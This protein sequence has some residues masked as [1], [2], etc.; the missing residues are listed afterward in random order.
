MTGTGTTTRDLVLTNDGTANFTM[1][2]VGLSAG[3]TRVTNNVTGNCGTTLLSGASCSIRVQWAVPTAVGSATGTVTITGVQGSPIAIIANAV[4]PTYTAS[5]SPSAI[6][7]GNWKTGTTGKET[8]T[9]TNTGNS[10]LTNLALNV[11]GP[12]ALGTS[13][14]ATAVMQVGSV[15][16]VNRGSYAAVPT[17][18]L[19]G[20]GSVTSGTATALM[21]VINPTVVS[22]NG[23]YTNVATP[24]VTFSAPAC[25]NNV[26]GVCQRATGTVTMSSNNQTNATRRVASINLNNNGLGY[27]S[28]PTIAFS[29][30]PAT[31]TA[32]LGV[33]RVTVTDGGTDY[34]T[35]PTVTF[36]AGTTLATGTAS[37]KVASVTVTAAGSGYV[38]A[39]AVTFS[40]GGGA[41]A[42]AT[43][44]GG[45]VSAINV[46]N[47]GGA[48]TTRP[49]VTVAAAPP[50]PVFAKNNGCGTTLAVGDTCMVDLTFAPTAVQLY[51]GASG[52][53]VTLTANNAATF[54]PASVPLT[55]TGVGAAATAT[56]SPN[57]VTIALSSV[58]SS[59]NDSTTY[60]SAD[61]VTLT[62]TSAVGGTSLLV[63][64]VVVNNQNN[65]IGNFSNVPT[66][67]GLD[68]CTGVTLSPGESCTVGVRYTVPTTAARSATPAGFGTLTFNFGGG[69][70]ATTLQ[71]I[72]TP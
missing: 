70:A 55:G 63:S 71:G 46:T 24:T 9:V 11:A 61:V 38:V 56:A 18:S 16:V 19:T 48:Y 21:R 31:A 51:A 36:S 23:S 2:T 69:S 43:L 14:S 15:N 4:A 52:G 47:N 59:P 45:S 34:A 35:A 1:P 72:P 12:T 3:F 53:T 54:T 7:F 22:A 37:L 42:T 60:S 17:V 25:G 10:P 41:N 64:S 32:T 66:I 67:D 20:G 26:Q 30:G 65:D 13:A 58:A 5:V 40:G 62:N 8:L 39:P 6:N 27:T 29:T 68:L 33:D 57:P 28:P 44:V 49:T 50:V